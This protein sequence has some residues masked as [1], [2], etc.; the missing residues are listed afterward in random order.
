MW[1]HQH[2]RQGHREWFG[3]V[4]LPGESSSPGAWIVG[5]VPSFKFP[6]SRNPRPGGRFCSPWSALGSLDV[7]AAPCASPAATK[8]WILNPR[9]Q[10]GKLDSAWLLQLIPNFIPLPPSLPRTRW[11]QLQNSALWNGSVKAPCKT[12]DSSF[13]VFPGI[14]SSSFTNPAVLTTDPPP[15]RGVPSF[16]IPAPVEYP[17]SG[18]RWLC[19]ARWSFLKHEEPGS[20]SREPHSGVRTRCVC[21]LPFL[22]AW[23]RV[24]RWEL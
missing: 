2:L 10:A 18:L 13:P 3:G 20:S 8:S 11:L 23:S 14:S 5:L 24:W 1:P 21:V 16:S 6:P 12:R 9:K 22:P 19:R 17:G 7:P 4:F 15:V